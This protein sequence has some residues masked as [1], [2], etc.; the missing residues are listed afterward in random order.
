M[1]KVQQASK[2]N[3]LLL[4][5]LDVIIQPKLTTS[6]SRLAI[7]STIFQAHFQNVSS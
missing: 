4:P 1:K 3:N 5:S 6:N 2:A 7:R